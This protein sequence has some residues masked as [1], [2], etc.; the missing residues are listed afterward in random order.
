HGN[1]KGDSFI[2]NTSYG[3]WYLSILIGRSI[4]GIRA[5][6]I[7]RLVHLLEKD[8]NID[9]VYGL[10]RETMSSAMLYAAAFNSRI[11]R[12]CLIRPLSSYRSLVTNRYYDPRFIYGATAGALETYDLPDLA[13]SLVPRKLLIVG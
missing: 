13:A 3:V 8:F 10:A 5:G 6:D 9:S 4:V 2:D 7:A 1:Y 11:K 12:L